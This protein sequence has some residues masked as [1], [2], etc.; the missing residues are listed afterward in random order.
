M[1]PHEI[2]HTTAEPL[3]KHCTMRLGGAA[4]IW[5]EPNDEN[6]LSSALEWA[7]RNGHKLFVL[8]AGSNIVPSDAGWSGAVLH[9]GSG[10][11]W[12]RVDGDVFHAGGA[13][14]LPKL[15]HLALDAKLG[16]MEWAC[17]IPGSV[18][19]SIWGNAGSRGFNGHEW[20]TRD[21]SADLV[22][23][24]AFDRDGKRHVLQRRDIEFSYRKSSLGELIVSEASFRLEP[25][26]DDD[27]KKHRDAVREL[28]RIR[29]ETQPAN[30]ASAGCAWKNP[31]HNSA[32]KLVESLGLK[33]LRIGGAQV[34][35]I[36][37]NFVINAGGASGADVRALL[38]EVEARVEAATGIR[39]EREVRLLD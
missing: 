10:F 35:E 12:H 15:T 16:N 39:L 24:V 4:E 31:A 14:L 36:H 29:R 3:A 34:S 13:L 11:A 5:L 38:S 20:E 1:T 8:G 27:T 32:G 6:E 26:S 33:G 18:G 22:S 25:L 2:P 37:G 9:L 28:L 19:G 21:C 17:G 30:A 23:L 7:K